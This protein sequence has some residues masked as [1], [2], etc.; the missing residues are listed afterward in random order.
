MIAN[1]FRYFPVV[2]IIL[3]VIFLGA[4]IGTRLPFVSE[5]DIIRQV[6]GYGILLP[7]GLFLLFLPRLFL[8]CIAFLGSLLFIMSLGGSLL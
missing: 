7:M 6:A 1:A 4:I 2:G 5:L 8:S 3:L